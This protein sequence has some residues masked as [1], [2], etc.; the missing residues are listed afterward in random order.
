MASGLLG[1]LGFGKRE[2]PNFMPDVMPPNQEDLFFTPKLRDLASRRISGQDLGFGNDFVDKAANP[3]IAN[4][5]ASFKNRTL[6]RINSE[7]SKRGIAR[8]SIVTDQIGQAEQQNNREVNDLISKFFTLN[9]AQK[10]TDFTQGLNLATGLQD[11]QAGLLQNKA[12]A[13]A[14]VRDLTA[15]RVADN[16]SISDKRQNATIGMLLN[17]V[18]PGMGSSFMQSNN[19]QP[20]PANTA[21]SQSKSNQTQPDILGSINSEHLLGMSDDDLMRLLISLG[22]A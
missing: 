2:K 20:P 9:E 6:P 15:G 17:S 8:S 13:S 3:A 21:T 14:K 5:D 12:D 16:N 11:Q 7:A 18:S 19:N 1:F 22:G 10:K 4:L